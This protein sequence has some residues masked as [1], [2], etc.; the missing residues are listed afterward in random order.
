MKLFTVAVQTTFAVGLIGGIIGHKMYHDCLRHVLFDT[1]RAL[2][3]ESE[4]KE[5]KK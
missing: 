3:D 1:K 5:E 2:P 4:E